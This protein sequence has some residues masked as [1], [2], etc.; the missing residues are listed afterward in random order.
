[1]AI[2]VILLTGSLGAGKTTALNR[3]LSSGA[4]GR[5]VA[6]IENEAGAEDVDGQLLA[7]TGQWVLSLVGGCACCSL[8]PELV[9]LLQ[10]LAEQ[11]GAFDIVVLEASGLAD[12]QSL[13]VAFQAHQVRGRFRIE[14][15]V[16]VVDVELDPAQA[17]DPWLWD[18]QVALADTLIL[19]RE[20]EALPTPAA[21]RVHARLDLL[22]PHARRLAMGHTDHAALF[23]RPA[24]PNVPRRD[25]TE[26]PTPDEATGF[27]SVVVEHRGPLQQ[28]ALIDVLELLALAGA[29]V[30]AKGFV[31][32]AGSDRRQLI[33]LAGGRVT[34][35]P[36]SGPAPRRSRLVLIGRAL[37]RATL[38]EAF[39]Q[40]AA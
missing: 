18:R 17:P 28:A 31:A 15:V 27:G 34:V 40:C 10:Q 12:P 36:A 23:E 4:G 25:V 35:R 2:P 32:L 33:E 3:A 39:D 9:D 16:T 21:G 38:Q 20:G 11:S 14:Q 6:V 29:L 26:L 30:R 5:R 22:N 19:A 24:Q 1:M 7:D 13:L 8:V 37:D